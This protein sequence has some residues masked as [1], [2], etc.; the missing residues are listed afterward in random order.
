MWSGS[1]QCSSVNF[2]H[3]QSSLLSTA[4]LWYT[5]PSNTT[6]GEWAF[7]S[8]IANLSQSHSNESDIRVLWGLSLLNVAD[9]VQYQSQIEPEK[10]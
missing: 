10:N 3:L 1:I 4:Y 5:N 6:A 7:L 2:K 8:S 9:Q